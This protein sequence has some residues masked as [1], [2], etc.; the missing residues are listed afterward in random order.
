MI[1]A[2]DVFAC[3]SARSYK[4][5]SASAEREFFSRSAHSLQ[6]TLPATPAS[7][8]MPLF[9]GELPHRKRSESCQVPTR[10]LYFCGNGHCL[11]KAVSGVVELLLTTTASV[12]LSGAPKASLS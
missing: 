1:G 8:V 9:R 3:T 5:S 4:K 7:L 6:A 2:L 12:V 10:S 11:F